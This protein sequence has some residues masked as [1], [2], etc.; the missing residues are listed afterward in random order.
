MQSSLFLDYVHVVRKH[1]EADKG[2]AVVV[3][4]DDEEPVLLF[5]GLRG[6]DLGALSVG[7]DVDGGNV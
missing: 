1:R 7:R 3:L 4:G 2:E 5:L 6:L